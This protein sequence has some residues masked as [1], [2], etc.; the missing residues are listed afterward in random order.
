MSET[1]DF[2]KGEFGRDYTVRNRVKWA[3]RV[4]FLNH[5]VELTG[6][7]SFLDVGCNAGWNMQALRSIN[8]QFTMSGLDVNLD[9]LKE[10]QAEGFDVVEGRADQ[11]EELFGH[12]AADLVM[13]SGVLIHIHQD[14]LLKSMK[15]IKDASSRY[16]L[17]V[18]YYS[19]E[20]KEISYRG[21]AGRLWSRPYGQ[22]Y[23][24][25]GLSLVESGDASG[26]DQC[27]Y[28]LLEK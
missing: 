8:Q 11:A 14:D 12:G 16:V 18:E 25:M 24:A 13:S 28:W 27:M 19:P 20:E 22:M 21:N 17:A 15:S 10:A 5:I 2:W 9:A 26:Y 3:E 23:V 6:A 7:T 1:V 4:P